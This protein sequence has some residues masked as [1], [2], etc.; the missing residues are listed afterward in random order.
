MYFE[1][2][3]GTQYHPATEQDEHQRKVGRYAEQRQ[4]TA[5]E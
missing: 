4:G 3:D 1:F 2:S 5:D